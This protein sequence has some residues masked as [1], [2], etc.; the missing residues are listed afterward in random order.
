M[1]VLMIIYLVGSLIIFTNFNFQMTQGQ[2]ISM[3]AYISQFLNSLM[4]FPVGMEVFSR[5]K[6][7]I[8]RVKTE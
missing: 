2:A 4:S 5:M 6:D 3:Y 8:K 1:V 7:I